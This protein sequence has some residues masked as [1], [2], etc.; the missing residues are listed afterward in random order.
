VIDRLVWMRP[1]VSEARRPT[2]DTAIRT[3][4]PRDALPLSVERWEIRTI[5][6]PRSSQEPRLSRYRLAFSSSGLHWRSMSRDVSPPVGLLQVAET[7]GIRLLQPQSISP[8]ALVD[9][10]IADLPPAWIERSWVQTTSIR[11]LRVLSGCRSSLQPRRP[12]TTW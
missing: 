11:R 2:I 3:L 6:S 8:L 12:Q 10:L 7:L 1:W 4:R 5:L 9:A